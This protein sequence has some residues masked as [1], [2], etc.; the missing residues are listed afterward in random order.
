MGLKDF[1]HANTPH[2]LT[3]LQWWVG[4]EINKPLVSDK[5]DQ[6]HLDPLV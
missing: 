3:L 5:T 4:A 6:I 2:R 1:D